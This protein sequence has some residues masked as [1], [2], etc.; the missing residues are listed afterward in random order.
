MEH[1]STAK[2]LEDRRN[3][4]DAQLRESYGRVVFSHKTHEKEAD[5][6]L[7]RLSRIK[8]GQIVLPAISTGSFVTVLLG[9]WMVGFPFWRYFFRG[10][11]GVELVYTKL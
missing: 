11:L 3:I 2:A 9:H 8:F 1:H 10:T 5:I 4:L 7:A 6:L